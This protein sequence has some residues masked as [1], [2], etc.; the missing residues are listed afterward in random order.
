[1]GFLDVP[2]LPRC[3]A[4][5]RSLLRGVWGR[6]GGAG[7]CWESNPG[8]LSARR[9]LSVGAPDAGGFFTL[10]CDHPDAF[11][12]FGSDRF[13]R[14]ALEEGDTAGTAGSENPRSGGG[15]LGWIR[16]TRDP[17]VA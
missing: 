8:S 14:G 2:A 16:L 13:G 7:G 12:E 10:S 6:T 11:I 9:A 1:P 15:H 5:D 3:G 17:H 4:R